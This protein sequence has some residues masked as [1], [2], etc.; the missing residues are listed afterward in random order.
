M[1]SFCTFVSVWHPELPEAH[2]NKESFFYENVKDRKMSIINKENTG[3]LGWILISAFPFLNC[4]F[5][6]Q[7]TCNVEKTVFKICNY[8]CIFYQI[9]KS[10][11]KKNQN[12]RMLLMQ[13]FSTR[14]HIFRIKILVVD[15]WPFR[16]HIC[17]IE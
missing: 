10:R 5:F 1:K 14:D 6:A 4:S 7:H 11:K 2:L 15:M 3:L 8:E 9:K 12:I 17:M 13:N 16:K